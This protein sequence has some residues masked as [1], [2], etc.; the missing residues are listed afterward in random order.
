[1][2]SGHQRLHTPE[3]CPASFLS[4]GRRR[5]GKLCHHV[6]VAGRSCLLPAEMALRHSSRKLIELLRWICSQLQPFNGFLCRGGAHRWC[7]PPALPSSVVLSRTS[8][9]P[10]ATGG[11]PPLLDMPQHSSGAPRWGDQG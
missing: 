11:C 6:Q 4:S 1:M 9:T 5:P 8:P 7:S 10:D 3:A 2:L